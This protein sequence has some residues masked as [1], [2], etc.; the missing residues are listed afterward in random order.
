MKVTKNSGNEEWYTPPVFIEAAR[1][2]M[3]GIHL[4]PASNDCAQEWIRAQRYFTK[5]ND[6]LR[7]RW[8]G[9]VWMNPPYGAGV[10]SAFVSKLIEE[11]DAGNVNRAIVFVNN[12]TETKWAQSLLS[13]SSLTGICFPR[14]RVRFIDKNREKSKGSPI[15][16]Q[17]VIGLKVCKFDFH[18]HFG[19]FG[20]VL[21][22]RYAGG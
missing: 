2:A 21:I 3:N 10:V 11:I 7:Q 5:Q 9:N 16:G 20:S 18:Q 1:K 13:H 12:C 22:N 17:M 8:M 19:G 14:R 15:Q 6:G 4:D